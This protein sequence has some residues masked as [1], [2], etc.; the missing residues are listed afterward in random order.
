MLTLPQ[1]WPFSWRL[2]VTKCQRNVMGGTD[3]ECTFAGAK[4]KPFT[5]DDYDVDASGFDGLRNRIESEV[6]AQ[7]EDD[8]NAAR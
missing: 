3:V 2:S 7:I 1:S 8:E 4:L 5:L 6:G